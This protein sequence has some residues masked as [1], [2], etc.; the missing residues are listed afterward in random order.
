MFSNKQDIHWIKSTSKDLLSKKLVI[1]EIQS[2]KSLIDYLD[3]LNPDPN[4]CKK[5]P[6]DG[7]TESPYDFENN[8]CKQS[9][10]EQRVYDS[11]QQFAPIWL[12]LLPTGLIEKDF[13]KCW[14]AYIITQMYY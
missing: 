12:S 10:A 1:P 11:Y 2:R 13:Q 14:E 6:K 5:Q 7:E 4:K 8:V 9:I 3:Y